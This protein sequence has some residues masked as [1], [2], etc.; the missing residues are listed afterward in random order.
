MNGDLSMSQDRVAVIMFSSI[1]WFAWTWPLYIS[2]F[3]LAT[4]IAFTKSSRPTVKCVAKV[5]FY[6]LAVPVVIIVSAITFLIVSGSF[7]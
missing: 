4:L 2:I 5:I 7:H 1:I 6:V 3:P